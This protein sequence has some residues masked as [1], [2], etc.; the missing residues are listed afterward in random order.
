MLNSP[1]FP[2]LCCL[3]GT[4]LRGMANQKLWTRREWTVNLHF[5]QEYA[6]TVNLQFGQEYETV[7]SEPELV[8]KWAI[9]IQWSGQYIYSEVG[10][11]YTLYSEVGNIYTVKWAIYIQWSGGGSSTRNSTICRAAPVSTRNSTI[12][13]AAPLSTRNSTIWRAAPLSTR[14]S[15]IWRAAPV[16][17]RNSTICRAAPGAEQTKQEQHLREKHL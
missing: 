16:S 10:N 12:W 6:G 4:L 3:W 15:T 13:R 9:Y 2:S 11:I 5:C 8:F 14:N 7:N 17:T 1:R